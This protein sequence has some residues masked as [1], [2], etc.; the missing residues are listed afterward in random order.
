MDQSEIFGIMLAVGVVV[1]VLGLIGVGLGVGRMV[2]GKKIKQRTAN[3]QQFALSQG[4]RFYGREAPPMPDTFTGLQLARTGR[5]NKKDN[6]FSGSYQGHTFSYFDYFYILDERKYSSSHWQSVVMLQ[7]MKTFL[8]K[9][10][11]KPETPGIRR[12]TKLGIFQDIDFDNDPEFSQAFW[13]QGEDEAAV[14]RLFTPP[15]LSYFASNP[16]IS[17]EG[18]GSTLVFYRDYQ[19][20]KVEDIPQFLSLGVEIANRLSGWGVDKAW[21]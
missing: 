12:G 19:M 8:P 18:E 1:T 17:V 13:L 2:S 7:S 20:E 15:V 21:A 5:K 16:G 10:T 11:M 3:V 6:F 9:F 14:R 4:F